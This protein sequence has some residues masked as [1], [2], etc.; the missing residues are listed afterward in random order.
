LGRMYAVSVC[1]SGTDPSPPFCEYCGL[2]TKN[3][4]LF[5]PPFSFLIHRLI[6]LVGRSQIFDRNTSENKR[7][8]FKH[9]RIHRRNRRRNDEIIRMKWGWGICPALYGSSD[10]A[11]NAIR[12]SEKQTVDNL[13]ASEGQ[14]LTENPDERPKG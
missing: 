1:V 3:R 14:S 4:L 10:T 9:G 6:G 8:R 2:R 13:A 12:I 11:Q 5:H 7:K